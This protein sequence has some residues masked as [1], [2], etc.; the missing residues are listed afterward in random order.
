MASI[1]SAAIDVILATPDQLSARIAVLE[2]AL[3]R[4]EKAAAQLSEA[5]ALRATESKEWTEKAVTDTLSAKLRATATVTKTQSAAIREYVGKALDEA[6]LNILL[7]ELKTT[8]G[9][10]NIARLIAKYDGNVIGLIVAAI[11]E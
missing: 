1:V 11:T 3:K 10:R 9:P 8:K 7:T 4:N 2:D 6:E 5:R